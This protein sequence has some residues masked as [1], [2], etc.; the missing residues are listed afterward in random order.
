MGNLDFAI[1]CILMALVVTGIMHKN[2]CGDF[3][4][5][6]Q[7]QA[8]TNYAKLPGNDRCIPDVNCAL[9]DL[10]DSR[11]AECVLDI[12]KEFKYRFYARYIS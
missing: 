1:L 6:K 7:C 9:N 8:L 11:V 5:A 2:F 3:P 12:P 10:I 4:K